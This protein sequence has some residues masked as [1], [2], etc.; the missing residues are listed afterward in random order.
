M[1]ETED[2]QIA[3]AILP[4][5]SASSG[6]SEPSSFG[7]FLVV[8]RELAQKQKLKYVIA[9]GIYVH[10]PPHIVYNGLQEISL[11]FLRYHILRLSRIRCFHL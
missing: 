1:G 8:G 10:S 2:L 9:E 3:K 6:K 4:S 11:T 5:S 7:R